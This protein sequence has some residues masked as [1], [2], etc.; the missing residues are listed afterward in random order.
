LERIGERKRKSDD[1][2]IGT[3]VGKNMVHSSTAIGCDRK[4][5]LSMVLAEN[6]LNN[7]DSKKK[8]NKQKGMLKLIL[9]IHIQRFKLYD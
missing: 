8:K 2:A 5:L 6:N 3:R 4:S 9:G 1:K 7:N